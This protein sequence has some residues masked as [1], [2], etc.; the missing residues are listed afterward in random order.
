[1]A[2]EFVI[3]K[4]KECWRRMEM[5]LRREQFDRELEDELLLHRELIER[6][7]VEA[8]ISPEDARSAAH[9]ALGNP[10]WLKEEIR[11]AWGWAWLEDALI[12]LRYGVRQL[13]RDPGFTSV[14]LL[15]LALGIGATTGMFSVIHAVLT[16]PYPYQ[17]ANRMVN[18]TLYDHSGYQGIALLSGTQFIRLQKS[19]VLDGAMAMDNWDM[20]MTN[21][22]VTESVRVAHLSSNAFSYL[23]VLPLVGRE[24][25]D[26]ERSL[27]QE[28]DHVAVLSFRFWQGHYGGSV[29]AV[30]QVLK[31]DRQNYKVI[32]VVP[33]RF[34]WGNAELYTPLGL[35]QDPNRTNI[36]SARLKNGISRESAEAE[37]QVLMEQFAK[38]TPSHFPRDF[39]LRVVGLLDDSIGRFSSILFALLGAVALLLVIGCL[40]VSILLLAKGISRRHELSVR[41]AIGANRFRLLRQLFTEAIFLSFT[42]ALAGILVAFLAMRLILSWLPPNLL[43]PEVEVQLSAPV[44]IFSV[45]VGL[46]AGVLFGMS[47]AIQFSRPSIG[48]MLGASAQRTGGDSK[49][50]RTHELLIVGQ[51]ALTLLLLAG[52]GASLRT[53]LRLYETR[54]GY[55]PHNVLSVALPLADGSYTK[56]E[57]RIAFYDHLRDMVSRLKGI[58]SVALS[59]QPLPPFSNYSSPLKILAS[60]S[61]QDQSVAIEQISP[62]YFSTL[63]IPLLQ[64]SIWTEIDSVRAGHLAVVNQAMAKRFWPRSSPIGQKIQIAKLKAFTTWMLDSPG[65]DGTVQI[66]GIVGDVPND[67]LGR[68]ILPTVYV[69]Y[70][71]VANDWMQLLIRTQGEPARMVRAVREQIRAVDSDQPVA[72]IRTA[73]EV[74]NIEGWG[75]ERFIA[76]LFFIASIFAVFLSA[77]GLYSVISYAVSRRTH[78]FGI[79]LA[80]GASRSHI[81]RTA[82]GSLGRNLGMG[83][84]VGVILSIS[85]SGPFM[86][87]TG[88]SLHD[89]LVL[90]C[91]LV[92]VLGA[93]ACAALVP[94][95]R[96]SLAQPMDALRSD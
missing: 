8:G 90:A 50:K 63:H 64:G 80:L 3:E 86:R 28:P 78:E 21:G 60:P 14:S 26:V 56:W 93:S 16:D 17:G 2:A 44:L 70:T 18:L 5:F 55:V 10:T 67:G 85:F 74:L 37:L 84:I 36:V 71:L 62:G 75:R 9:R 24:F 68:P 7:F 13:I 33:K 31:L 35:A 58:E 92:V 82:A 49:S 79:R 66:I 57:K 41:C 6:E 89:P 45:L 59:S 77:V 19:P 25:T 20:A 83:A 32:G 27:G 30:G 52:T 42:G 38:D 48:R 1:M 43:P 96:A 76:A 65:N 54:L 94:A 91:A 15:S 61:D 39:K 72:Q 95:V 73:E 51:L 40:N 11:G 88:A 47:P 53:F 69:P 34:A 87:W 81:I 22:Q 4:L 29:A 23:G 12:D 46:A